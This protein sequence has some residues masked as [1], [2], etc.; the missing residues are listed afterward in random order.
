MKK[1]R[2]LIL[3]MILILAIVAVSVS[4]ATPAGRGGRRGVWCYQPTGPNPFDFDFAYDI[5][6][7]DFFTGSYVSEWTGP[8]TGSSIDNGLVIWRNFPADGPAIFVDLITFA[9]AEVRGRTGPLEL[10]LDGERTSTY[11]HGRWFIANA[12]GELTGL[13]GRGVWWGWQGDPEGVCAEG[14][15]AV[16]YSARYLR[17]R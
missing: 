2:L 11:W 14:Y 12:S 13:V 9:E 5:G 7:N 15:L 1:K 8:L 3:G 16:H 4:A 10:Y 17:F 6:G